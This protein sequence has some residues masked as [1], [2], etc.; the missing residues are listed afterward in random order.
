[1]ALKARSELYRRALDLIPGGVNSP[2]RAMRAMGV[3]EPLFVRSGHGAYVEDV[4]GNRYL[5]WVMSWGPL[6]FGHADPETIQAVR[7]AAERNI[8]CIT[9]TRP[10][11]PA[12]GGPARQRRCGKD[13]S[14]PAASFPPHPGTLSGADVP[15][16]SFSHVRRAIGSE[17]GS[18]ARCS[19]FPGVTPSPCLVRIPPDERPR[20][21]VMKIV[22]ESRHRG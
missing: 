17:P 22:K 12:A 4:N 2:V 1:M 18:P 6:L 11:R 8:R 9:L 19:F 16:G 13:T 3:D 15:S 5:D 21:P 20:Y 14:A 10:A 7:D